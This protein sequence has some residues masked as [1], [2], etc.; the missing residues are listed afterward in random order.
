MLP[1][2]AVDTTFSSHYTSSE[3]F[4][5]THAE[6]HP[7]CELVGAFQEAVHEDHEKNVEHPR[8]SDEHEKGRGSR[9][10]AAKVHGG[11]VATAVIP[12]Q[13]HLFQAVTGKG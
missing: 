8:H 10:V 2:P 11:G 9:V 12:L 3:H 4:L 6:G 7:V 13:G 5:R 1:I